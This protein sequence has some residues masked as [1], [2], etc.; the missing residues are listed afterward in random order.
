MAIV[1]C[2]LVGTPTPTR[3]DDALLVTAG[4]SRSEARDLSRAL[5]RELSLSVVHAARVIDRLDAQAAEA[6]G[7]D[8]AA[9]VDARE[10][11][12]MDAYVHLR[13]GPAEEA[14]TEAIEA[15]MEDPRRPADASRLAQ[16][17]FGRA[18]VGLA[19]QRGPAATIDLATAVTLDP[20]LTPDRDEYGPPVLRAVAS[21]RREVRSQPEAEVTVD[22]SPEDATVWVDGREVPAGGA[23]SVRSGVR[24]LLTATR[25]GHT[26]RSQW[27]EVSDSGERV[28]VVLPRISGAA[29]S[30]VALAAWES[31]DADRAASALDESSAPLVARAMGAERAVIARRDGGDIELTLLDTDGRVIRTA[32]GDA[33]DWEA[34]PYTVLAALLAGRTLTPPSPADVALT[35]SAPNRV[36]LGE[37]IAIRIQLRDPEQRVSE[38]AARCGDAVTTARLEDGERGALSLSVAAPA[39]ETDVECL[40]RAL[41]AEGRALGAPPDALDVEVA[42]S[43]GTPFYA[44][45][46]FWLAVGL[47]VAGGVAAGVVATQVDQ[48]PQQVL[49]IHGP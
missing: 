12:A 15:I 28:A 1:A 49:T 22:R 7:A 32:S 14:F 26:P 37:A 23:V 30:L 2:L 36:G 11:A 25:P 46:Y 6:P 9:R 4:L 5:A 43:E 16:L 17:L 48:E 24:H 20:E 38:V 29:L 41:D 31:A 33:V 39:R 8:V 44:A 42:T 40:V 13:F 47:V 19:T 34:L 10:R 27:I 35:V 21:A 45:W 18:L 3:A